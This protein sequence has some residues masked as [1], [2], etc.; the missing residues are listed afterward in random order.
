MEKFYLGL[1]VLTRGRTCPR[2][3]TRHINYKLIK[4]LHI[5]YTRKRYKNISDI[6]RHV[7]HPHRN[8]ILISTAESTPESIG[9]VGGN[10][11]ATLKQFGGKTDAFGYLIGKKEKGKMGL[12]I[13]K[14]QKKWRPSSRLFGLRERGD[15]RK[16]LGSA[17]GVNRKCR[18]I[19]RKKATPGAH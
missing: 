12:S 3:V 2:Y 14:K 9:G 15:I 10:R 13:K 19:N 8:Y 18:W 7:R 17:A 11:P 6:C 5:M 4:T 16:R 1:G